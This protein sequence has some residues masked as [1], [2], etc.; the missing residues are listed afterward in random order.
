MINVKITM[1]DGT[2]FDIRNIADSVKDFHKK[3]IAPYGTNMSFVEILPGTLICVVNIVSIREMSEEEVNKLNT[4]EEAE[5]EVV[6]LT[7]TEVIVEEDEDEKD[8]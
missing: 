4:P 6:G 5:D 7:E 2:E 3:V 8:L 1:V